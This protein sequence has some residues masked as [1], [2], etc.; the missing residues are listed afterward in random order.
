MALGW[1]GVLTSGTAE[2]CWVREVVG[3]WQ[4][5]EGVSGLPFL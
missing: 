5:A 1:E 4:D 2:R 3:G